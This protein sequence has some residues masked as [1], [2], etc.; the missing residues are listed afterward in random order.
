MPSRSGSRRG[1]RRIPF[2]SSPVR[3]AP[4]FPVPL[5]DHLCDAFLLGVL[6]DVW[7]AAARTAARARPRSEYAGDDQ[8][9]QDRG[10]DG[11]GERDRR[12]DEQGWKGMRRQDPPFQSDLQ[13]HAHQI[14]TNLMPVGRGVNRTMTQPVV[15]ISLDCL[16]A[17]DPSPNESSRPTIPMSDIPHKLDRHH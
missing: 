2:V 13:H 1:I 17:S 6:S 3:L 11:Q 16:Q 4:L 10:R 8:E 12:Q 15:R 5:C 9:G 14:T 7:I